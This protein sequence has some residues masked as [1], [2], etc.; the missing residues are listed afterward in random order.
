MRHVRDHHGL[1][2]QVSSDT[3]SVYTAAV[4]G[5]AIAA[6]V[7]DQYGDEGY[8]ERTNEVTYYDHRCSDACA[9][10]VLR[11]V[12]TAADRRRANLVATQGG[13]K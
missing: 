4:L 3:P 5:E 2:R 7:A 9:E 1:G 10:D 8:D 12:L 11:R 6:H 13:S